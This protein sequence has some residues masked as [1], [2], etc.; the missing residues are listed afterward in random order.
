MKQVAQAISILFHPLLLITLGTFFILEFDNIYH[1]ALDGKTLMIYLLIILM[2]TFIF[3]VNIIFLIQRLM[4]QDLSVYMQEREDRKI[5]LL[6][7]TICVLLT[8]YIFS[9]K[10]GY[11]APHLVR[12]YLL[13]TASAILSAALINMKY[14]ISLHAIGVGGTL[15]LLCFLQQSAYTDLRWIIAGWIVL[16]GLVCWARLYL[17]SHTL[18]E[19]YAGFLCGFTLIFLLIRI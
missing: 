13:G 2:G 7:A 9:Y 19:I 10:I 11:R 18:S 12:G 6:I 3:P 14:K 15:A 16:S 4:R 5:P 17:Q 1:V 8:F